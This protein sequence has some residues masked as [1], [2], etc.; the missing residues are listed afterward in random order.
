MERKVKRHARA[1]YAR[2]RA[3]MSSAPVPF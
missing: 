2:R 3:V 1:A